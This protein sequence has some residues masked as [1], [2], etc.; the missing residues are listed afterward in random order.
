M[1]AE[2]QAHLSDANDGVGVLVN[3]P[4]HA[5]EG[6]QVCLLRVHADGGVHPE[7]PVPAGGVAVEPSAQVDNLFEVLGYCFVFW[8]RKHERGDVQQ[9][10]NPSLTSQLLP[11]AR[12]VFQSWCSTTAAWI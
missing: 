1:P 11:D 8:D 3:E 7:P 4:E 12:G 6:V 10:I 5:A 9:F 2:V